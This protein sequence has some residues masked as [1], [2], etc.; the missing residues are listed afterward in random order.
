MNENVAVD[1]RA[2]PRF[3]INI[4]V[5]YFDTNA[6][7][8]VHAVTCDISNQGVCLL[9]DKPLYEGSNCEFFLHMIDT[10]EK[11][12]RKGTV[13][14]TGVSDTGKYKVAM[15]LDKPSL[16]ATQLVLRTIMEQ[17]NY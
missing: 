8:S 17:K 13:V 2:T 6:N 11:I 7:K 1:R 15:L 9:S 5:T 14:W 12:Y 3:T 4:P 16:N 10:G